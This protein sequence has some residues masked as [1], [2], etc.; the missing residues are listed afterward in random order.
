[1]SLS[2]ELSDHAYRE[3]RADPAGRAFLDGGEEALA[4]G[5][6]AVSDLIRVL[7]LIL[8]VHREHILRLADEIDGLK[9][10]P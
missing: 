3:I 8:T 4:K 7:N 10:S 5:G 6:F 9:R 1:M 2:A